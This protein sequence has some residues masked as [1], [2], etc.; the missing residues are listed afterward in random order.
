MPGRVPTRAIRSE[1][2]SVKRALEPVAAHRAQREIGPK[3]RTLRV[4][5]V[6]FPLSVAIHGNPVQTEFGRANSPN[7]DGPELRHRVPRLRHRSGTCKEIRHAT[8]AGSTRFST[9]QSQL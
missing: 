9:T 6:R 5:G 3:M 2:P 4:D 7:P 1:C 8:A